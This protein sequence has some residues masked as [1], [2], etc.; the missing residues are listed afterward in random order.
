MQRKSPNNDKP[1]P[2][3]GSTRFFLCPQ[4]REEEEDDTHSLIFYRQLWPQW[5]KT[6]PNLTFM[7]RGMTIGDIAVQLT[8]VKDRKLV[9]NF[10]CFGM[11]FLDN[12]KQLD[13]DQ[14]HTHPREAMD[15]T[16]T[17]AK[18]YKSVKVRPI[19]RNQ[20]HTNC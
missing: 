15:F 8:K 3:K 10:F 1:L 20:R 7:R 6:L 2:K 17:L 9:R 11:D 5:T 19:T 14:S 12:K 18:H 13:Y 4:C 16:F